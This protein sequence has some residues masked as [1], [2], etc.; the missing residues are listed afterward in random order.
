MQ[1]PPN[2][3]LINLSS[4][5]P[6]ASPHLCLAS[7]ET[8]SHQ[9]TSHYSSWYLKSR[10]LSPQG[11]CFQKQAQFLYLHCSVWGFGFG[12]FKYTLSELR[13][14]SRAPCG[15]F[16]FTLSFPQTHSP[17]VLGTTS[18]SAFSSRASTA[19]L[20]QADRRFAASSCPPTTHNASPL[21]CF[22]PDASHAQDKGRATCL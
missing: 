10:H 1:S 20:R 13:S 15:M 11:A 6:L 2:S 21:H 12:W 22:H 14:G 8:L 18:P 7:L 19:T 3:Q 17:C 4:P 5:L 9:I 16:G